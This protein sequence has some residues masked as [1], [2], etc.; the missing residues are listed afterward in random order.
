[1]VSFR[2]TSTANFPVIIELLPSRS[3]QTTVA[4][5]AHLITETFG[6]VTRTQSWRHFAPLGADSLR[7]NSPYDRVKQAD[8]SFA[9]AAHA[10]EPSVIIEVGRSETITE[11][12][13]DVS[14]WFSLDSIKLVILFE[15][16]KPPSATPN[17][18]TLSVEIWLRIT[19][20]SRRLTRTSIQD[21]TQGIPGAFS[22][23][24]WTLLGLQG[25]EDA[26]ADLP[27]QL[28]L[29]KY[30]LEALRTRIIH[31]WIREEDQEEHEE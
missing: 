11:L 31:K 13:G 16:G 8:A 6:A 25:P 29:P 3:H 17:T 28:E 26:P 7:L 15:I 9:P 23:P 4:G 10:M 27:E 19:D 22:I 21:W 2:M 14:H 12:R 24:I 20:S 5:I 30:G 18:P 1:M